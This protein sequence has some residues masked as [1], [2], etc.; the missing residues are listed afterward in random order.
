[1]PDMPSVPDWVDPTTW[2][3]D[4]SSTAANDNGQTPDLANLPDKPAGAPNPRPRRRRT[5]RRRRSLPPRNR[6]RRPRAD[7]AASE[8]LPPLRRNPAP[9]RSI[10]Q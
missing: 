9:H 6:Y 3:G 8:T 5:S 10:S 1:L 2:F 7:P 4:D